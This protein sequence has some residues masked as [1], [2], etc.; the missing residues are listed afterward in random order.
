[1]PR[2]AHVSERRNPGR[3]IVQS[4]AARTPRLRFVTLLLAFSASETACLGTTFGDLVSGGGGSQRMFSWPTARSFDLGLCGRGT[5]V[6]RAR[7]QRCLLDLIESNVF[8][9][10]F[11][12][13]DGETFIRRV[14]PLSVVVDDDVGHPAVVGNFTIDQAPRVG[15]RGRFGARHGLCGHGAHGGRACVVV[16]NG[17]HRNIHA[18]TDRRQLAVQWVTGRH[19]RG[20]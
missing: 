9:H 5:R 20:G 11:N 4:R 10:R 2:M 1:M 16:G 13:R 14:L 12:F 8:L 15:D 3:Q 6:A 19:G 18:G 7:C 17:T